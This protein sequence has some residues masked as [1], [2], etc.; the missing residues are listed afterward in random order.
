MWAEEFQRK[1]MFF[2]RLGIESADLPYFYAVTGIAA[3]F[4]RAPD[5]NKPVLTILEYS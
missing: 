5:A 1:F 3:E 4:D 2:E